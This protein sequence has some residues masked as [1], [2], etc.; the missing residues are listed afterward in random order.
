VGSILHLRSWVG[1]M[2][3][4]PPGGLPLGGGVRRRGLI[5][6]RGSRWPASII[7]PISENSELQSS[8]SNNP[9]AA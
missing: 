6:W 4:S 8:I 3:R 2:C 7:L 9:N 1:S 5:G